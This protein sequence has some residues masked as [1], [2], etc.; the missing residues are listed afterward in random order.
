M[1]G[2]E[3]FRQEGIASWYG[4]EFNGRTTA[5]GEIY[6]ANQLTA[7]HPTLPFGTLVRVT[8]MTNMRQ[9]TV[10]INDRGPFVAARIIDLS[11]AAAAAL[12]ML[13]TGQAHV[14][15]EGPLAAVSAPVPPAP[16]PAP[17]PVTGTLVPITPEPV[18]V[19]PAP[20]PTYPPAIP[21][22]PLSLPPAAP[23][24]APLPQVMVNPEGSIPEGAIIP[25]PTPVPA[26]APVAAP[27]PAPV[28]TPAPVAA[29][30]PV[31][32]PVPAQPERVF[33]PA[34]PATVRP[35]IPPAESTRLYRIQ[36]GSYRVPR[37]ALD[38]FDR[39]KNAGLDPA[40]EQ[41]DDLYRVV[42]ARLSARDI[43]AIAQ[44]LGNAG[45]SEVLIRE[46]TD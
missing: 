5:S 44:I 21:P 37:N 25:V 32:A 8:N 34:P 12:D 15:I 18:H 43:P 45:F 35:A 36:V 2:T 17:A 42:L 40:Y 3:M 46:E 29:P 4:G 6:D 1:A 19:L 41:F 39:L 38:V 23:V 7:A 28:A 31:P 14:V 9:V 24:A 30:A 20:M 27:V 26:P 22:E 16:A 10:R 11:M 33:I 13:Y